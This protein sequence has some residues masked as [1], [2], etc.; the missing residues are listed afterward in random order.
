MDYDALAKQ[1]GGIATPLGAPNDEE[2]EFDRAARQLGGTLAPII[3]A[4][5]TPTTSPDAEPDYDALTTQFGGVAVSEEPPPVTAPTPAPETPQL[6]LTGAQR[7]SELYDRIDAGEPITPELLAYYQTNRAVADAYRRGTPEVRQGFRNQ[8][9]EQLAVDA[10]RDPEADRGYLRQ[11]Q[12]GFGSTVQSMRYF[13]ELMQFSSDAGAVADAAKTLELYDAVDRGEPIPDEIAAPSGVNWGILNAYQQGDEKTRQEIRQKLGEQVQTA[14]ERALENLPAL[15]ELERLQEGQAPAVEGFTSIRSIGD[16]RDWL[17]YTTGAVIPQVGLTMAGAALAGLPGAFGTS[18]A[19]TLPF[20]LESRIDFVM[21]AVKDLPPEEQAGAVLEYLDKTA[22]VSMAVAI[23]QG[24]LNMFGPVGFIL[25][26]Q[27]EKAGGKK[28][29]E[30]ATKR[31]A[32]KVLLKDVAKRQIPEEFLTEAGEE[33]LDIAGE[34]ILGEQTGDLLSKENITRITDAAFAGAVGGKVGGGINVATGVGQQYLR[35]RSQRRLDEQIAQL[36]RVQKVF[37]NPEQAAAVFNSL[38][39][40]YVQMGM[41]EADASYQAGQDIISG[42]VDLT[43]L[44]TQ[45]DVSSETTSVDLGSAADIVSEQEQTAPFRNET[46]YDDAVATGIESGSFPIESTLGNFVVPAG[47][48]ESFAPTVQQISGQSLDT[49]AREGGMGSTAALEVVTGMEPGSLTYVGERAASKILQRM[50]DA[51][52]KDP[53]SLETLAPNLREAFSNA[54]T[55]QGGI[56]DAFKVLDKRGVT[57]KPGAAPTSVSVRGDGKTIT[58]PAGSTDGV[59]SSAVG[60]DSRVVAESAVGE[61]VRPTTL[62]ANTESDTAT[63]NAKK[64]VIELTDILSKDLVPY[65][66]ELGVLPEALENKR[67]ELNAQ[68]ASFGITDPELV[69]LAN[70]RFDENVARLE[71]VE[72]AEDT[73]STLTVD[74]VTANTTADQLPV[75]PNTGLKPPGKRRGGRKPLNRTPEEQ[76]AAAQRRKDR[77]KVGRDAI[78]T[79]DKALQVVEKPFN[80]SDYANESQARVAARELEA[81]RRNALIDAHRI[82]ADKN[83]SPNSKAKQTARKAV[84][85]PSVDTRERTITENLAKHLDKQQTARSDA[86]DSS[87]DSTRDPAYT[88][89]NNAIQA[90]NHIIKTGNPFE[91]LLAQRL[92]PFLKDVKVTTVLNPT[93]NIPDAQTRESF[94]GATGLYVEDAGGTRTIYLNDIPGLDGINNMT[95]LHEA[96]HGATMAQINSW[97]RNPSS[98]SPEAASAISDMQD[99]MV[100]AGKAY[101]VLNTVGLTDPIEQRLYALDVFADLKEFVA[102]G[103]TQPEMQNFLSR[104]AGR[105]QFKN[106]AGQKSLLTKF[107]ESVRKLFRMGPQHQDGFQDLLVITDRLLNAPVMTPGQEAAVAA[108]KGLT[109]QEELLKKIQR[110]RP[111]EELT[112]EAGNLLKASRGVDRALRF[113]EAAY[114][115][116][117]VG[118]VRTALYSLPSRDIVRWAGDRIKNLKNISKAVENLNAMKSDMVR[119]L[120]QEVQP[121]LK[122]DRKFRKG[123]KILADLMNATTLV[124][125]DPTLHATLTDALANDSILTDLRAELNF[126][127]N[128]PTG[129]DRKLPQIRRDITIR[130]NNIRMIYEGGTSPSGYRMGGWLELGRIGKGEGQRIYKKTK[131][132]YE[133]T[134]D[135]HQD[136]L[137]EKIRKSEVPG[138]ESDTSTPKGQL[139][140]QLTRSYQEAKQLG[141]YFPLMRFGQHW[142]RIGQGKSSEFFMFESATKRN[143]YARYRAEEMAA[144]GDTRGYEQLIADQDMSVGDNINGMRRELVDSSSML[145]NIFDALDKGSQVDPTTGRVRITDVEAVKDQVYQMYLMTLP[146]RDIRRRFTHRQGRTGFTSDAVRTFI[147]TQHTAANQLSRLAYGDDIRKAIGASYAEL[148]GNPNAPKLA[149]FVNELSQRA[150]PEMNPPAKGIADAFGR[151]GNQAAFL[152]M[153]SSAKS[154]VVQMTQFPVVVMPVLAAEYGV[155]ET[156]ATTTPYLN[157]FNRLGLTKYNDEGDLVTEWGQPSINDSNYVNNHPDPVYRDALR[158]AWLTA[159]KRD[160]F[161]QTY[162]ADLNSRSRTPSAE[163][164][165]VVRKSARMVHSFLTGAFFHAERITREMTYMSAFELEYK[166]LRGQE[167]ENEAAINQAIDKAIELTNEGIFDYTQYNKPRVMTSTVLGRLATQFMTFSAQITSYLLRNFRNMLPFLNKEGKKQAAIKFFGTIGMVGMFAGVT[168]LPL[169]SLIMGVAEAIRDQMRPDDDDPEADLFYDADDEGNPLGKRNLDLWFREY[170]IPMHFGKGSA[171]AN[172]LGLT[173]E[174]ALLLQRSVKMGPISVLTDLDIGS[175]VTLNN[176][177]FQDTPPSD[178]VRGAFT[179]MLY[180]GALGPF[181]SMAAQMAGSIDDFMAGDWVR[182]AEKILPAGLRGFPRALRHGT[183]GERTRDGATIREA[184]WFHTGKI[185]GDIGGFR[186]TEIAEVQTKNF[187][188]RRMLREIERDRSRALSSLDQAVNRYNENPTDANWD[189]V[190]NALEDIRSFNYKNGFGSLLITQDTIRR[191]LKD[192]AVRRGIAIEGLSVPKSQVPL[193]APILQRTQR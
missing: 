146:E 187:L 152:Y 89:F 110:S 36:D 149:A 131:D 169:Y 126:A 168:R 174:Q 93:T 66:G 130:E 18:L 177:W 120:S 13:P 28:I 79:A 157:M 109:S 145:K 84:D 63:A 119:T 160:L 129:V 127:L 159:D 108:A 189:R 23:G 100:R 74:D 53:A 118:A 180:A 41:S 123:G 184:E 188:A 54:K 87:T 38:V 151:I 167:V 96:V 40:Q 113:L 21:D 25:R 72:T 81:E 76:E 193:V 156:L 192:R 182:G 33:I 92:R 22:D 71:G 73:V 11:M 58:E 70:R 171:L 185:L 16:F 99:L 85:H 121:W 49:I 19:F 17:G 115:A 114:N 137:L 102:Y 181:G 1:F 83:I 8:L 147:A 43:G 45:P 86:L 57:A 103:M 55:E 183:E 94:R 80:V 60:I 4:P 122:F 32:A 173:D 186:S 47:L 44:L 162:T 111:N 158:K 3:A 68:L 125:V 101:A 26:R 124:N 161:V 20:Q 117:P 65:A 139:I 90:L 37:E 78:R 91:R 31:E 154:A 62:E 42:N 67:T 175:S 143:E 48:I 14:R 29:A 10:A 176:L 34:R 104:V 105:Y 59:E 27:F 190:D 163:Q 178:S 179:D 191:S 50:S 95:F 138:T 165:N 98:V 5:A 164:Y 52:G 9:A 12:K 61:T 106:D 132:A 140:S 112:R 136:L 107:V 153:L 133:K 141:V 88:T 30:Y 7:Q 116:M 82:L 24:A 69:A 51:F 148:A 134:F 77:Q 64:S 97:I 172:A 46:A 35:E 135:M 155:T 128:Q 75:N 39:S 2:D 166:K 56:N 144:R 150:I 170:F 15:A 142:L 6:S